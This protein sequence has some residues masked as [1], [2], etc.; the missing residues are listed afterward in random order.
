V[1]HDD[2]TGLLSSRSFFSELRRESALAKQDNRPFCVLMMDVDF[3]KIV[4]DTFGLISQDFGGRF[5]D[6]PGNFRFR[7]S[8]S[9]CSKRR[10]SVDN[11][12]DAAE[13]DY[14]NIHLFQVINL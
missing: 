3:F 10:Q 7:Q 9:N 11:I 4:N 14:E 8:L 12:A 5:F 6:H 13:S 1:S 2:L